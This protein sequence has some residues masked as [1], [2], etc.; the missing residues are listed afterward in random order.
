MTH[1]PTVTVRR[2]AYLKTE[3]SKLNRP[4]FF[5]YWLGLLSGFIT[6]YQEEFRPSK[7]RVVTYLGDF[8]LD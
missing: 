7:G 8:G 4:Q 1:K 5:N 2:N 6:K 3:F